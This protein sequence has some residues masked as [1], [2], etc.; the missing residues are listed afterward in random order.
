M[1]L[2]PSQDPAPSEPVVLTPY[3]SVPSS[4]IF[5]SYLRLELVLW[6]DEIAGASR[7]PRIRLTQP[8]GAPPQQ[9]SCSKSEDGL[10]CEITMEAMIDRA[11]FP[12]NC[13]VDIATGPYRVHLAVPEL[14]ARGFAGQSRSLQPDFK[15]RIVEAAAGAATPPRLLDLGGRNR[16]GVDVEHRSDYPECAVTAFDIVADPGVDVVGDAHELSRYFP[17]GTFDFVLCVSVFEHLLMPWKVALEMNTVMKP[18]AVA[19]IHTHQTIG[20]HDVPWDFLRFSESCWPG[21]F[22]TA[23]GFE[24]LGTAVGHYQ[25]IVPRAWTE[26]YA[27]AESSGGFE[28]SAVLVRKTGAARL[29]WDVRLGEVLETRYPE[30]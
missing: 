27:R 23:T 13:A 21:L 22:N 20:M 28:S 3:V 26:R 16:S 18:G 6:S 29:A 19:F 14:L 2:V 5:F 7:P 25:H 12:E 11:C 17:P 10:C 4:T 9:A 8:N 24:V 15:Q 1:P 30:S